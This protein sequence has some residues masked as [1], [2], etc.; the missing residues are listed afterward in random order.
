MLAGKGASFAIQ[1]TSGCLARSDVMTYYA[2]ARRAQGSGALG[3]RN[4][5][6]TILFIAGTT[7]FWLLWPSGG[8][9]LPPSG[10]PGRSERDQAGAC[11]LSIRART[12]EIAVF[13]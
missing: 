10:E 3:E 2:G 7:L 11:S 9:L 5:T 13:P 6:G 8:L 4:N 12:Q 1:P